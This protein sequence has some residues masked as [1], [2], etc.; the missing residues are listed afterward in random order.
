[1]VRTSNHLAKRK[2]QT[3][4]SAWAIDKAGIPAFIWEYARE[5]IEYLVMPFG[6]D[7][8]SPIQHF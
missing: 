6:R 2:T 4:A 1:M 7:A 5:R 3:H 8:N